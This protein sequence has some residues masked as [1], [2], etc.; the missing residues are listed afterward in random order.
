MPLAAVHQS[1]LTPA[2]LFNEEIIDKW[3]TFAKLMYIKNPLTTFS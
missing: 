3:K 2:L 1:S